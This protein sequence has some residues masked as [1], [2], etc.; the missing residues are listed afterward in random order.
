MSE[1]TILITGGAGFIG[2]NFVRHVLRERPAWSVINLDLLA[3]SGSLSSLRGL[4]K[5]P[6][7][8]FV[9]G[10]I[11][12]APLVGRLMAECD[13]VVHLAA[14]S[15]VD[16]SIADARPFVVTNVLGTHVLLEAARKHRKRLVFVSTDEVYG[17]LALDARAKFTEESP[18][19]P[20][21]PY[22][23][24]KAGA[25]MLCRAYVE[26][27]GEDVVITRCAN[28]MGPWQFPEKIIPLF[29]T[30]LIE[31]KRVPLYGDGLN[32]RDWMHVEDH[33]AALLA[34]LER[35]ARGAVYNIGA[36]VER[37]NV[38][39]TREVLRLMKKDE[40]SIE[41][42]ADRAGHD[43]RYA[44]DTSRI[45]R[46]LGWRPVRS[47]WPMMLEETVKWYVEHPEWWKPIVDH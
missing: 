19:L 2:A 4:E 22:A 44:L 7:H 33:C 23:A 29:V 26:T 3:Y 9:K 36:G 37:S 27:H 34:V 43:R 30:S 1:R 24:S 32:V 5:E 16:R 21:S 35:A 14:E 42:V 45:Q 40:S 31:G 25:D 8:R 6:R 46:E 17:S 12:D 18:L 13:G 11:C 38:V 39:L 41:R 47:A 20:N 28:N 15:H 10:D